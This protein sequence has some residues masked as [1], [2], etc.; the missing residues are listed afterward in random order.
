MLDDVRE[1][2]RVIR[3]VTGPPCAG[4]STHVAE[5]A[6]PGDLVVD[7]DVLATALGSDTPHQSKGLVRLAAL[8]ARKA[9]IATAL[10]HVGDEDAWIIH[11]SPTGEQVTAYEAAGAEFTTLDPGIETCLARAADRP[12]GTTEAI[13]AWY[14]RGDPAGEKE[15]SMSVAMTKS[16]SVLV[17]AVGPTDPGAAADEASGLG[18]GEF[19]ALV[20]VFGNVDAYGDV[21]LEGAFSDVLAEYRAK[22]APIPVVWSH[23]WGDVFAHIGHADPSKAVETPDGLEVVGKLDVDS[24]VP[25]AAEFAQQVHRLLAQKRIT[26]FSFA[27]DVADAGWGV[28]GEGEQSREVFELRK[29]GALHEVG[30]CLVGVNRETRL[31]EVKALRASFPK[32]ERKAEPTPVPVTGFDPRSVAL[33]ADIAALD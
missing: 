16:A 20:S 28:R 25:S 13:E 11:T 24:P 31:D 10:A 21:V 4:K 23:D 18:P 17:K 22:G 19:K 32:P 2:E 8:A 6:Q 27:F 12:D 1:G 26:Q 5:S 3:V 9:V 30:P 33:L 7:Y 15:E 29:F 14:E